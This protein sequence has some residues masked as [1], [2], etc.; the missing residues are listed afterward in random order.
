M[1]RLIGLDES[2]VKFDELRFMLKAAKKAGS[3]VHMKTSVSEYNELVAKFKSKIKLMK[4]ELA[5]KIKQLEQKYF[6]QN[7][8]LPHKNSGSQYYKLLK[9]RNLAIAILKTI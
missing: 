7:G 3:H 1:K 6:Q 9:D 8:T 2:L 4:S 5:A